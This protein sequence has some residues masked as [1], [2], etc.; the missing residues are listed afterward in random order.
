MSDAKTGAASA[1]DRGAWLRDRR[2]VDEQQEDALAGDYD[3]QWGEIEDTHQGF[4]ERFLS[5]LPPAGRVLDAA[6]G[7]GNYFAM[8]L[9]SGRSLL[10]VDHAGAALAI[11]AA[12]FPQV[13]TK[14]HDLQELPYQGEFDGV[15]C[16]DAMEFVPPED[17]PPVL[18][19]FHRALH[20]GGW[21]YLTVERAPADRVRAANQAARRSGLPVVDGEVIWDEPDGYYHH[22][23]SMQQVRAW[24]ADARFAIEEETE[25]PW[26]EEG[27]AYH[28][29][30]ARVAA[31]PG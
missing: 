14:K 16:V 27:Y 11:A 19:R 9:A 6:C 1:A 29:V 22:Y 8:V 2:R 24:L 18:E 28:H 17:W 30:L 7:T 12:K 15:L 4:M 21:L 25:G 3:T 26:H 10:G 31:P 13:P 23:P 20:S 5:R